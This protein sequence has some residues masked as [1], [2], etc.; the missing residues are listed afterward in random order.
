MGYENFSDFSVVE[1]KFNSSS[2]CFLL[3]H[4]FELLP[5]SS[6]DLL[7]NVSSLHEMSREQINQYYEL[8]NDKANLFYT[9]QWVFWE[10]PE[11]NIS[12]PIVVYPT[13]PDWELVSARFN[14]VHSDFF[15]ALFK[16]R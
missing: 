15:E 3:P 11:D 1:E 7:I 16:V 10:N 13:K 5:D 12:V 14:P 9:K 6:I 8:I 4:Q 2:I